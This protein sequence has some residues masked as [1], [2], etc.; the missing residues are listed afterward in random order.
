MQ[1]VIK[2]YTTTCNESQRQLS[3]SSTANISWQYSDLSP[4][5]HALIIYAI[6]PHLLR[7][8][9]KSASGPH[10]DETN[11][12]NF[13]RN[14]DKQLMHSS[15]SDMRVTLIGLTSSVRHDP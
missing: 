10:E 6:K 5:D 14:H 9:A 11:L 3:I 4:F 15:P 1:S 12:G 13:L 2:H 7:A 8:V